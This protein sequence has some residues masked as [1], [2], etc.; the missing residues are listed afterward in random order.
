MCGHISIYYKNKKADELLIRQLTEKIRH[1]GPDDTRYFIKDN[2][3]SILSII[4][5]KRGIEAMFTEICLYP[6]KRKG[7]ISNRP[8]LSI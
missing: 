8:S 3:A 1:R 4:K 2:I 5:D 6:I 7:T